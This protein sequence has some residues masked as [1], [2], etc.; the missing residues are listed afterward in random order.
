M[1][2]SVV[3]L[4]KLHFQNDD[5][6]TLLIKKILILLFHLVKEGAHAN[7]CLCSGLKEKTTQQKYWAMLGHI[8]EHQLLICD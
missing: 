1:S 4:P 5:S 6:E 3:A 2:G 8:P 7:P